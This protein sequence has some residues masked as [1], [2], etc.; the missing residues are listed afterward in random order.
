MIGQGALLPGAAKEALLGGLAGISEAG[1]HGAAGF[2]EPHKTGKR[3]RL[4]GQ[5]AVIRG[6]KKEDYQGTISTEEGQAG[7]MAKAGTPG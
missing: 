3:S 5:R 1:G 6:V 4:G 2:T 7:R